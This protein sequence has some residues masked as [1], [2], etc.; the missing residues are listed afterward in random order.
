[1]IFFPY[2]VDLDLRHIPLVTL[3]IC[4]LCIA[5]FYQQFSR[6]LAIHKAATSYCKQGHERSFLLVIEK[7][8]GG[9]GV[10]Q[11]A[12]TLMT[13]HNSTHPQQII[14]ELA[15]KAAEFDS[16]SIKRGRALETGATI[17]DCPVGL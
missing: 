11:C 2:K 13:L 17:I 14:G 12:Q 3:L 4:A 6:D 9:R 8:T 15:D 10:D 16:L 5:V 7:I 1:M